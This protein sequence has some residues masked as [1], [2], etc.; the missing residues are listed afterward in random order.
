[1]VYLGN[2][3]APPLVENIYPSYKVK[4][5]ATAILQCRPNSHPFPD[6]TLILDEPVKIGRSVARARPAANNAIFDC[7]VLSRNHA[8]LWYENGK[9]YLKDTKSSNGTFVNNYRLSKGSEESAPQEVCSGDIVQYGVDVMENSK[10]GTVTHGCIIATLKLYLPDGQEAKASLST[11]VGGGMCNISSQE[12]HQL[13]TSL[14]EAQ[15]REELIESKLSSFQQIITSIQEAAS[16]SWT[17][18]IDED[19]LLQRLE[20]LEDQLATYSKNCTDD[21]MREEIQRVIEEKNRYETSAKDSIQRILQEKV[22]AVSRCS[23]LERTLSVTKTELN[24]KKELAESAQNELQELLAKQTEQMLELK[25]LTEK[26]QCTE[27]KLQDS[28]DKTDAEK[29][30]LELKLQEKTSE[31]S[32]LLVKI[33]SLKADNDFTKEQLSAVKAKYENIKNGRLSFGSI[34]GKDIKGEAEAA[35]KADLKCQT[36]KAQLQDE[37]NEKKTKEESN[38]ALIDHLQSQLGVL[39]ARLM[40]I[41]PDTPK[42]YE[43]IY[44]DN[45]TLCKY[46][47]VAKDEDNRD[48]CKDEDNEKEVSDKDN[49]D[50]DSSDSTLTLISTNDVDKNNSLNGDNH[51]FGFDSESTLFL[52]EDI[53]KLKEILSLTES[54]RNSAKEELKRIREEFGKASTASVTAAHEAANLH[55]Q[56]AANEA[57]LMEKMRYV[58]TLQEIGGQLESSVESIYVHLNALTQRIAQQKEEILNSKNDCDDVKEKLRE[59]E[60]LSQKGVDQMEILRAKLKEF[61]FSLKDTDEASQP[62]SLPSNSSHIVK[63]SEAIENTSQEQKHEDSEDPVPK[64]KAEIETL[65]RAYEELKESEARLKERLNEKDVHNSQS[66]YEMS[67]SESSSNHN[68]VETLKMELKNLL[69]EHN[70]LKEKLKTA[71][72]DFHDLY[73]QN[74][75]AIAMSVIPLMILLVG[76][77]TAF[78]DTISAITGTTEFKLNQ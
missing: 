4:M 39:E 62:N 56:L 66:I 40:D 78:Y 69:E 55:H 30:E 17:A 22:D 6:R 27:E 10:K 53:C 42:I 47:K 65:Q 9:F 60:S 26:L 3:V 46:K 58:S 72:N 15:H 74:K 54:S 36:M 29:R 35:D 44:E 16:Q 77:F 11:A 51:R 14:Q 33:E 64:L 75:M 5:P 32:N 2:I 50:S 21:S 7:K 34:T 20:T 31:G 49:E 8:L 71:D 45:N 43:D 57:I 70:Q 1:M 13:R 68:S 73:L 25:K 52:K 76:L 67:N 24:H 19:R 23:E 59:A 48:E 61:E 28:L 18:M 63:N 38:S 37:L 12:L 41:S